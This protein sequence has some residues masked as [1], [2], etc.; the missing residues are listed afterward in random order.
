MLDSIPFPGLPNLL[1]SANRLVQLSLANIPHS[2]YISPEAMVALLSVSSSL[3]ILH[4]EFQSSQSRP[5]RESQSLPPPKHPIFPALHKF[6]F[7]GITE[8]LEDLVAFIDAPQLNEM[9]STFFNQINFDC[10]LTRLT[11]FI[12]RTAIS[13]ECDNAFVQFN[14]W[15]TSIT[16]LAPCSL[17]ALSLEIEIPCK[18]P[19]LQLLSIKQVCNSSLHPL[20]TVESLHIKH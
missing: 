16:L 2:G 19:D 12:N 14:N 11:Q 6:H 7:I 5:D 10:P 1:L 15:S 3:R 8:Y 18:V 17:T 20:S 9:H 13:R 4:L